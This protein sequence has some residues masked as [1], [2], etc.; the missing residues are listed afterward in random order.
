MGTT[1]LQLVLRV[2][3]SYLLAG[4]G[5]ND[6]KAYGNQQEIPR[7]A[8]VADE[9]SFGRHDS[10][11][12]HHNSRW[13]DGFQVVTLQATSEFPHL[14]SEHFDFIYS[15]RALGRASKRSPRVA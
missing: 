2:A 11:L 8:S 13:A 14:L 4:R 3:A 9:R 12:N 6:S 15:L 10:R 7:R 1:Q 5:G